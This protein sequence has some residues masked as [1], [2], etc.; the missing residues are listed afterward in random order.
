[1]GVRSL[2]LPA[3]IALLASQ[4]CAGVL[5]VAATCIMPA[6]AAD[7]LVLEVREARYAGMV[8]HDLRLQLTPQASKAG[9]AT[10]AAA[11]SAARLEAGATLGTLAQLRFDCPRALLVEPQFAC[12]Q[13]RLHAHS[14][15]AGDLQ[16]QASVKWRSDSGLLQFG[17]GGQ[18]FAGGTLD[19]TANSTPKGWRLQGSS[20]GA[21]VAGLRSFLAPWFSL[22]KSIESAGNVSLGFIL[23]G[24]DSLD[25]ADIDLRV[26]HASFGNE[27][28]TVA[29]EALASQL[30]WTMRRAGSGYELHAQLT[31]D[32]GQALAGPVLLD[33]T[34]NPQT[35]SAVGRW[36]GDEMA[37]SD[38]QLQQRGLSRV[39]GRAVL[40]PAGAPYLKCGSFRI[41]ELDFPAAY[42]SFLQ[43]ALAASDFGTLVTSG[44]LHGSAELAN[45]ALARL[46]ATIDGVDIREQKGK[47]GMQALRGELHWTPDK[48]G[49][50]AASWLSWQSGNAYGLS[51]GATRLD[52]LAQGLGFELTKTARVPI[53]DGALRI[54]QL[55]VQ[56][57][58]LPQM[59]MQFVGEIEPISMPLLSKAF[60]WPALA[61]QLAGRVPRVD[62]RDKLL[63]FSGDVEAR[64]FNGSVV[65]SNLRLKDPLGPWPRLFADVRARDLDLSMVTSTFSIGSITGRLEAD[66]LG[67]ELFN[68]S[69]VAFDAALRTPAGDKGRHRIS[70][71]AVGDLSN[72]GGGG[73]GVVKAL[74]SG[75]FKMFDEYDYARLG[76][77]CKLS[78]EV[79]QMSGVEQAGIGYYILQGKG[80]PHIDI[81]G[82]AGRVNWRQLVSQIGSQMRGEGKLLVN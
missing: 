78:N 59:T 1:M 65:G 8:A 64:V 57:M 79:C 26:D 15:I 44:R 12:P 13:G 73:G 22:P 16:M 5:C 42:T 32:S 61:G 9:G 75:A 17:S 66:I 19:I 81:I 49:K 4:F 33:F 58:T 51:G 47:F 52:F 18:K 20:H 72:I 53:F 29:G 37:F 39:S 14:S 41:E 27:D 43:I 28:A 48:A 38:I 3:W 82:N 34:A 70:A 54:E 55:A 31:S 7:A 11:I 69:P 46:D 6:H 63:T 62:Y 40:R 10:L 36:D 50:P 45:D 23:T 2:P 68:W 77:R 30:R 71:R 35:L 56:Q 76:L 74:Q 80:L 21:G 60:G 24:R 67:L 25:N